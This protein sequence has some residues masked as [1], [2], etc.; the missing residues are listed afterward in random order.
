MSALATTPATQNAV[1]TLFYRSPIPPFT[2]CST[3]VSPLLLSVP[4]FIILVH[5][6]RRYLLRNDRSATQRILNTFQP[7]TQPFPTKFTALVQKRVP[8]IVP[9]SAVERRIKF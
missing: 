4:E 7:S 2:E 6:Q 3:R 5:R 8:L 9:W 1:E